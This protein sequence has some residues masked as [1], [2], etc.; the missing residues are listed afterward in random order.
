MVNTY[1]YTYINTG[2]SNGKTQGKTKEA[3]FAPMMNHDPQR[4][5]LCE[6]TMR[7]TMAENKVI[8][9]EEITH[10]EIFSLVDLLKSCS[11]NRDI[12]R[13]VRI[14]TH[15]VANHLL[16]KNPYLASSLINMYAKCGMLKKAHDLL[17]E[18]L[19]RDIFSWSSLISGY[20]QQGR[21]HEALNCFDQMKCEGLA[22]NLV[23]FTCILKACGDGVIIEKG[24]KIHE[25][26]ISGGLLAKDVVLGTSLVDMYA[27]C[28]MITKAQEVFDE[29]FVKNVVTWYALIAGYTQQGHS[30]EAFN[31]FERM[32][33][34]GIFPDDVIFNSIL[35]ASGSEGW[36]QKGKS[37]HVEIMN[38]QENKNLCLGKILLYKGI[39]KRRNMLHRSG[40][41]V[42]RKLQLKK[43]NIRDMRHVSESPLNLVIPMS[44]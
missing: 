34:E 22:P 27:K 29:L 18:L 19:V 17:E 9:K 16:A 7:R 40:I 15:I 36:I 41:V 11:K 26:I 10:K 35:K 5:I 37:I 43:T 44:H 30:E 25:E 1:A 42:I 6:E 38:R 14:H 28:G 8:I 39:V 3:F 32:R 4:K 20:T 31:C 24:I 33:N 2:K 21:S 23:I 13:G 12:H